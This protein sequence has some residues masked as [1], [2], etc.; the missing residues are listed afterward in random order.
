MLGNRTL[1]KTT[2]SV[3]QEAYDQ[4]K[5]VQKEID[6]YCKLTNTGWDLTQGELF[7]KVRKICFGE[8]VVVGGIIIGVTA[9]VGNAI[10]KR[11]SRKKD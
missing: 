4:L 11:K 6:T 3:S 10:A 1:T 5:V 2:L 8:G 7:D 9:L